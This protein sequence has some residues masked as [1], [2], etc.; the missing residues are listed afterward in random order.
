MKLKTFPRDPAAAATAMAFLFLTTAG[1]AV[2]ANCGDKVDGQRVACACGDVVVSDTT[3]AAG[4]PVLS[5]PCSGD[6]LVLMPPSDSDGITLDLGGH[7]LV[8]TGSGAGVR[9]DRGGRLGSSIIGGGTGAQRAEIVRFKTGIRASGRSVLREI[10]GIDVH[11][12]KHDGLWLRT[13]G[14]RVSDV[15]SHSNGRDGIVVSG[16]G[17]EVSE[18]VSDGNIR[19]GLQVRGSGAKVSAETVGNRRNGTVLGARSS[20]VSTI[21]SNDNGGAGVRATGPDLAISELNSSGNRA[22]DVTGRGGH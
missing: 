2:A 13:S 20:E 8:G 21:R 6:A 14:V 17:N 9:V 4:D 1:V 18:V 10:R 3:L 11:D 19:D 7:A 16:H 5:Q 12:N 22:G 15:Y